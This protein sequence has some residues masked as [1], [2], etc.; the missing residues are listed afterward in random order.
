MPGWAVTIIAGL[1]ALSA[2]VLARAD[3][4]INISGSGGGRI[5]INASSASGN[6]VIDIYQ[7]AA[8]PGTQNQAGTDASPIVQSGS[9][10][11]ARLG[12]GATYGGGV[13]T[14]G[15]AVAGNTA[16][17]HQV[18]ASADQA[19]IYQATSGNDA[20][21]SQSASSQTAT[22]TQD[23][24]TG[25]Q[26]MLSQSGAASLAATITQNG[27]AAS[28]L[29][30]T[31][32]ASS[33]YMLSVMQNGAGGHYAAIGTSAGYSDGATLTVNQSGATVAGDFDHD[34]AA[35]LVLFRPGNGDWMM[36]LSSQDFVAG[37][38]LGFGLSTDKPVPGDYDGDGRMDMALYRP[39]NGT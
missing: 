9:G 17:I 31:Q 27:A 32:A 7:V 8:V 6:S 12:Q 25:N 23:G 26:A 39:S 35:D 1:M 2:G 33:A 5:N 36:R 19:S 3:N 14:G 22:I 15:A 28:V 29:I 30:A 18:G 34:R 10:H 38:D 16:I 37:P 21:I 11:A 13:W 4:T 20:A 24:S